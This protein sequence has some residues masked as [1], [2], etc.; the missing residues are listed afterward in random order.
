LD[1]RFKTLRKL[2]LNPNLE[3]IIGKTRFGLELNS[4]IMFFD[5][6]GTRVTKNVGQCK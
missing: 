6:P 3:I 2:D 5:E 1:Q 4:P